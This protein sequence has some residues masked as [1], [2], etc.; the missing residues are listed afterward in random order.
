[1]YFILSS[2]SL[3][4]ATGACWLLNGTDL[5]KKPEPFSEGLNTCPSPLRSYTK[6]SSLTPHSSSFALTALITVLASMR[7]TNVSSMCHPIHSHMTRE[8]PPV[9]AMSQDALRVSSPVLYGAA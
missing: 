7:I 8:S 5:G 4:V 9:K 3:D 1:M 6:F 2:C